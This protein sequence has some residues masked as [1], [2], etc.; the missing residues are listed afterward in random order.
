MENIPIGFEF[1]GISKTE[2][3]YAF[4]AKQYNSEKKK[5]IEYIQFYTEK[6]ALHYLLLSKASFLNFKNQILKSNYKKTGE[7]NTDLGAI[8][9]YTSTTFQILLPEKA[10]ND[11]FKLVIFEKTKYNF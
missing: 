6:N 9:I 8:Y 5:Y 4:S 2:S 3:I 1:I 10:D 11:Y 7:H